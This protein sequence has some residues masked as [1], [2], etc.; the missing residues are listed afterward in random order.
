M[1]TYFKV[2]QV[3]EKEYHPYSTETIGLEHAL[4]RVLQ[5]DI[6]AD[7]HMPPFDKSAMDGYAC[8]RSDLENELEILEVVQAGKLPR[9]KIEKNQCSKIMTGAA[10]PEGADCVF[11][12]ED[13]ELIEDNKVRCTNL[14]TKSNIRIKGEDYQTGEVLIKKGRVITPAHIGTMAGAGYTRVSASKPPGVAVISTGSELVAPG[15]KPGAGQIRNSNS[16]QLLS[17]LKTMGI[18]ATHLGIV[19]DDADRIAEHFEKSLHAHDVVIITGG[20]SKG[21][22]EFI[23]HI[24]Q[25]HGFKVLVEKTGVKPGNPMTFSKKASKYCF[26]LSGNPVSSFVQFELFVKPFIYRGLGCN[27]EP[28]RYKGMLKQEF[29]RKKGGRL[30]IIPVNIDENN[31]I[32]ETGFHGSAHINALPNANALMEVPEGVTRLMKGEEVYVRRI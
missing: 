15:K 8:R 18:N 19:E 4:G 26:G 30:G 17:Q 32:E 22:V 6:V 10:I 5:E 9:Q 24:L 29:T 3:I 16:I 7:M 28:L 31:W 21:E 27:W 13:A 1:N 2:N 20:A 23:P 12:I 14:K 11:M 25:N